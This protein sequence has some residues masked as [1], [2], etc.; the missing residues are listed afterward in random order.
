MHSLLMAYERTTVSLTKDVKVR[1]DELKHR[2]RCVSL[3]HTIETL[4]NEADDAPTTEE[5]REAGAGARGD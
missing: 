2:R 4:L 3:D 1:L 5:A